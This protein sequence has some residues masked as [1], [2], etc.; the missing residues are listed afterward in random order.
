[1]ISSALQLVEE[2][3]GIDLG[4]RSSS[5]VEILSDVVVAQDGIRSR[6]KATL[7]YSSGH[8]SSA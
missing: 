6:Y 3:A 7:R 8:W 5:V 4:G 2:H 1:M